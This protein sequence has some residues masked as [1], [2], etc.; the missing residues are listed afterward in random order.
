MDTLLVGILWVS[1]GSP[2]ELDT[3]LQSQS[4]R[5]YHDFP[6]SVLDDER[7]YEDTRMLG[8][9]TNVHGY[10]RKFLHGLPHQII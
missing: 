4:S 2:K 7:A 9:D 5:T 6:V 1:G 3:V 8:G 10:L